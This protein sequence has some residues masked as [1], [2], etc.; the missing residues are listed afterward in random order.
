MIWKKE[1][2]RIITVK[3]MSNKDI[4][5]S[6]TYLNNTNRR[7]INGFSTPYWIM[8]F[9]SELVY[10]KNRDKAIVNAIPYVVERLNKI[11]Y[12]IRYKEDKYQV[13]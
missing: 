9:E 4:K 8:R 6:L 10:R 5:H 3:N 13:I 1:G 7:K 11:N 12:N 2:D